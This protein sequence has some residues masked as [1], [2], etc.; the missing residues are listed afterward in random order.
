MCSLYTGSESGEVVGVVRVAL[1]SVAAVAL[2]AA[3]AAGGG[4]GGVDHSSVAE[5]MRQ[6]A[7]AVVVH[8]Q[9][10]L[11]SRPPAV[12]RAITHLYTQG[13]SHVLS[14]Q[15]NDDNKRRLASPW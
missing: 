10:R 4:G 14:F 7:A 12:P 11:M 1:L 3:A 8:S 6:R 5:L 15:I 13:D 9:H 2:M